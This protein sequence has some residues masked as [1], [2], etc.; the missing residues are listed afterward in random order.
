MAA[1]SG[2]RKPRRAEDVQNIQDL[3]AYKNLH[4]RLPDHHAAARNL[5]CQPITS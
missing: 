4:V 2:T 3:S 1:G 5:P